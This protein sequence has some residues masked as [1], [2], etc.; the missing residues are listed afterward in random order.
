MYSVL[1]TRTLCC[2]R[3]R[4]TNIYINKC[5]VVTNSNKKR[6]IRSTYRINNIDLCRC[7]RF[8]CVF[9]CRFILVS[10]I[11]NQIKSACILF[12]ISYIETVETLK[13]YITAF[14]AYIVLLNDLSWNTV[15]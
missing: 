3:N 12:S 14:I 13:V 10:H 8:W 7:K 5:C 15:I 1:G 6:E 4:L 2:Y 9:D 11:F